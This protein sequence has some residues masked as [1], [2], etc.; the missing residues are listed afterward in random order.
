MRN[1]AL[2]WPRTV[3]TETPW[4]PA[5][6]PGR[7]PPPRPGHAGFR[8]GEIEQH[9]HLGF[10]HPALLFRQV[11]IDQRP[12]AA[13]QQ[14][15]GHFRRQRA[16]HAHQWSLSEARHRQ[17][18]AGVAPAPA[19]AGQHAVE[20][21]L[22]AVAQPGRAQGQPAMMVNQRRF[23]GDQGLRPLAQ[24]VHPARRAHHGVGPAAGHR[25]GFS[26]PAQPF[27]VAA[28]LN[29]AAYVGH[30]MVEPVGVRLVVG[31]LAV[32]ALHQQLDGVVLALINGAAHAVVNI[33][34]AGPVIVEFG[35]VE[36]LLAAGKV[37][38]GGVQAPGAF[39]A[40]PAATGR[41]SRSSPRTG[42]GRRRRY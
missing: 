39:R 1:T 28:Q 7:G 3:C 33:Q 9:G 23:V 12:A 2:S 14:G 22:E 10:V 6:R 17:G 32:G 37:Q 18:A 8:R 15:A 35:A 5:R 26:A 24:I 31:A 42:G 19:G 38:V 20:Q 11:E 27:T 30:Q 36:P 41:R 16:D 40:I 13:G 4:S 34:L 21:L 25:A 29:G